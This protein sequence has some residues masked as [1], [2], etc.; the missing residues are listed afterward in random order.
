MY[1]KKEVCT[2]LVVSLVLFG[3]VLSQFPT[4]AS[5]Q[6]SIT[7]LPDGSQQSVP[8]PRFAAVTGPVSL[9][10]EGTPVLVADGPE[11]PPIKPISNS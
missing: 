10:S 4:T 7:D 1:S 6:T 3:L 8:P 2:C 11:P 5:S 9:A